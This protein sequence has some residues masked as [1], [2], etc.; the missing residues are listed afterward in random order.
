MAALSQGAT[1]IYLGRFS[2]RTGHVRF[3]PPSESP[4][5]VIDRG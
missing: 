3:T 5:I 2:N 1:E 4:E